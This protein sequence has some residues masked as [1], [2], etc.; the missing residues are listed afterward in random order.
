MDL[1]FREGGNFYMEL[2]QQIN[3]ILWGWLIAYILL[4]IGLYYSIRLGVPQL[5]YFKHALGV[6]KRSLKKKDGEVS[7]FATLCAAI[8]GQ[9]GTGSLVGVATALVAGGPG[10]IF[11]M[12][13]TALFGM[14]ITFAETVLGQLFREKIEDGTYRGGPAYY[15][16]KGLK[17]K[18]MAII[19]SICYI[20]AVGMF[21]ASIQ[22]NS[23]AS[24]FTGVVDIN[25]LIPGI[26]VVI[27]TGIVIVG[28]VKR[29]VDFSTLIVPFMALSFIAL[30]LYIVMTNITAVP[31]VF[32]LIINSAFTGEVAA[33]GVIG[34]TVME[35][36]RYGMARGLFSNDAGNGV[37]GTMHASAEVKHPVEQ[38][39]LAMLGTFITTIIICSCTAFAMLLTD[40]LGSGQEGVNLLQE[41]FGVS[42]GSFGKWVVFGAMFLFGFTTL[43]ADVF[44][45]ETNIRYL[46]KKNP[47][48]VIWIYRIITAIVLTISSI[49]PL[50]VIWASVDFILAIIIF[51]NVIALFGLFKYVRYAFKNY[52]NQLNKGIK[53]PEWDREI[54]ITKVDLSQVDELVLDKR[55]SKEA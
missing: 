50:T 42:F 27:L 1:Y 11:W 8:G 37:A 7:G 33:G 40:V 3:D 14:V 4:G 43:L 19:M 22:T 21:I 18:T 54:D 39:F 25:P 51:L 26:A 49:V 5:R 41:A 28:G 6:M 12:W 38:S 24:A 47:K 10:A 2:F 17:N 45:G 34:A 44:Y 48:P 31:A 55:Y 52:V 16:E 20:F 9:V 35:A 30:S 32:G 29:L 53:E 15:I 46:F 36:F 23:I 13:V